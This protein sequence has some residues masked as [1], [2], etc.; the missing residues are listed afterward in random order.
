MI[1]L[2]ARAA[3]RV[4]EGALDGNGWRWSRRLS[5]WVDALLVLEERGR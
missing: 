2:Q 4:V 5:L 1:T 3:R